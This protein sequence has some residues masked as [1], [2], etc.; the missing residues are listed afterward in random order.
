MRYSGIL[1]LFWFAALASCTS[2]SELQSGSFRYLYDYESRDIH[3]EY[4]V[5]HHRDDSSTV[6][7]RIH[8]D[9]LLYSRA[10]STSPFQ[11]RIGIDV[12]LNDLSGKALD[13]LA[14]QITDVMRD[15]S[16]WLIGNFTM[17]L[18]SGEYNLLMNFKDLAKG[19]EQI[20]YLR[21]DKRS[22]LSNQ[23]YLL[24]NFENGEPVFTGFTTPGQKLEVVSARNASAAD[25]KLLKL[26]AELKLPPPPFSPNQ[27]EI[28]TLQ[29]AVLRPLKSEGLGKWSFESQGGVYFFTHDESL[30]SGLT[31]KTAGTFFP[32]VKDIESLQWPLRYITTKTEHEEIVKNNYPKQMIDQFWIE[33]A[34]GKD[35]ARELIR[36]YYNRVEE[37]NL[38]FSSYTEGWRTDRGMIHLIFG[39]PGKITRYENTELWQYGEEGSPGMLQFVFRKIDTPFSS[40][41]YILDRD[42]NFRPYWE[43]MVQ[44]WRS[45][46]IYAE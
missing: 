31:I 27:P 28:P 13:T 18:A 34:G 15:Q 10:G 41:N 8:A 30:N 12:T 6:F 23:N 45:G 33:C 36:I 42:P 7:F 1:L 39:N 32:E 16:G 46:R 20:S 5:Y 37:A 26:N 9:E 38:Y 25:P 11:A 44:T 24:L 43:K 21:L 35:H 22:T 3:P 2:T 40:N 17:P 4:L 14:I 19:T 29:D